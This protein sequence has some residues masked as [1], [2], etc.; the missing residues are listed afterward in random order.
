[1]TRTAPAR[2]SKRPVI[3]MNLMKDQTMIIARRR[4]VMLEKVLGKIHSKGRDL[5]FLRRRKLPIGE[6]P[7][8]GEWNL[9]SS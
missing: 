3:R 2:A 9:L 4:P 6:A 7:S 8:L 1:M 5:I